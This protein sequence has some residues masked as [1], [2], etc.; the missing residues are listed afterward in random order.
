M[1]K[2]STTQAYV[3]LAVFLIVAFGGRWWTM[4]Y[5]PE[6]FSK[7]SS[8]DPTQNIQ[9][10]YD[11]KSIKDSTPYLTI[12]ASYPQFE[13]ASIEFNGSIENTIKNAISAHSENSEEN[14]KARVATSDSA[15]PI[16]DKPQSESEKFSF[17]AKWEA[18]QISQNFIS[19]IIRYGGFDGGAHGYETIS[20]FNY[21]VGS[22]KEIKLADLFQNNSNYLS[23]ISSFVREDI[24]KQFEEKNAG[25]VVPTDM[26]DEG[27]KPE[28]KN[29][30]NFTFTDD[31][32]IF[33]FGQ[34][35][36]LPYVYGEQTVV[37]PRSE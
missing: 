8:N 29:F 35:Q 21:D 28:E 34:Y 13:Q 19:I 26:I 30:K 17:Y 36:V 37:M 2:I 6:L 11:V 15:N 32:V 25:S 14:W 23:G 12:D 31:S 1:K 9:K 18:A 7:P 5:H 27:T 33:Y 10:F 24:K 3:I 22:Q 4:K 16:P 20:T